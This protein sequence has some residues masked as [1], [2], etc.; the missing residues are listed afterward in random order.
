MYESTIIRT[1]FLLICTFWL[2]NRSSPADKHSFTHDDIPTVPDRDNINDYFNDTTG[3][4]IHSHT[5]HLQNIRVIEL[6][7][8]RV[9]TQHNVR[10]IARQNIR[11]IVLHGEVQVIENMI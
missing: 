9:I 10:V 3:C 4:L 7:N 11:V 6:Q 1:T 5:L 8:I 2:A